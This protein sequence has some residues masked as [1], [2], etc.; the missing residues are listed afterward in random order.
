MVISSSLVSHSCTKL[1]QKEISERIAR[2]GQ[3]KKPTP[4]NERRNLVAVV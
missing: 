1:K 3:N 4:S 2:G